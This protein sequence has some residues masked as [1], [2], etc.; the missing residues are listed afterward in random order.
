[1]RYSRLQL[2]DKLNHEYGTCEFC[3]HLFKDKCRQEF[4]PD[5]K[6][7]KKCDECFLYHSKTAKTYQKIL[8]RFKEN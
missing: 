2:I 3:A 4:V 5:L 8:R 6:D 1:M 7:F